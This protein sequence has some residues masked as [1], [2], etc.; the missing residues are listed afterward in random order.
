RLLVSILTRR[1]HR[2]QL[3]D[4]RPGLRGPARVSILTRRLH[5]VQRASSLTPCVPW[6]RFQSSLGVSTECNEKWALSAKAKSGFQSS[7]GVST[8]CNSLPG[9]VP[10]GSPCFNPHSAS[11]PSATVAN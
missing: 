1:L 4:R 10:G 3:D 6:F 2:V 11:P 8:E 7:L 5:R 9:P